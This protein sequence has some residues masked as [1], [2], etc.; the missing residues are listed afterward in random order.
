MIDEDIRAAYRELNTTTEPKIDLV[1][2]GCPHFT[3][4]KLKHIADVL[5]DKQINKDIEVWLAVPRV[6][7]DLATRMDIVPTIERSGARVL[8][9]CCAVVVPTATLGYRSMA[10][11]SAKARIYMSDFGLNV[12]FGTTN[13]CLEAAIKGYWEVNDA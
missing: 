3:I 10:T 5:T 7:K 11:D 13:Q 8:T 2:I 4:E 6:V 9:D 1:F 12:R